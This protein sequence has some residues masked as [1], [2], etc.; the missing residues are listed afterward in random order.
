MNLTAE[1]GQ[2][3]RHVSN[4]PNFVLID[5]IPST[6]FGVYTT[7]A[8][9]YNAPERKVKFV[10]I[11][12]RNGSLVYDE[13]SFENITVRYPAII[14]E[15][16]EDNF[17]ALRAFLLSRKG[18]IRLEDTFNPL[19]Y[20][21]GV[22]HEAIEPKT[23]VGHKM[24]SFDIVFNCKPQRFLKIGEALTTIPRSPSIMINPTRYK[25]KPLIRCYGSSGTITINGIA[26]TVTGC[27]NYVDLDCD[28]MESYE[29]SA[30]RNSTTTLTNG[31]F[32]V[33]DPGENTIT[34][35]GFS[36]VAII[37]RFFMI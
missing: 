13:D 14:H 2:K 33:L 9:V 8:G 18:Y 15:H 17:A 19:E 23:T 31:L 28:L 25:A 16:Y 6:D 35:S 1:C 27:T 12:G 26:V 22:Y 32:P 30:S 29:G 3:G 24:G 4:F 5:G 20:R 36:S 34:F 21:L 37:P 11:P 10:D 7:D